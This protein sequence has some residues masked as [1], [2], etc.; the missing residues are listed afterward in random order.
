MKKCLILILICFSALS[1][2]SDNIVTYDEFIHLDFKSKS[3][4]IHLV[5]NFVSE[6]ERI[7]FKNQKQLRKSKKYQTY[8]KILNTFINSA[9]ANDGGDPNHIDGESCIYA[10]WNSKLHKSYCNHPYLVEANKAGS[11]TSELTT[12]K[13]II[14]KSDYKGGVTIN[15]EPKPEEATGC[16][17][18]KYEE[19]DANKNKIACNPKL[20]GQLDDKMFCVEAGNHS[21]NASYL[22]SQAIKQYE[23]NDKEKYNKIMKSIIHNFEEDGNNDERNAFT[24]MM[25]NMYNTCACGGAAATDQG[26]Y[27]T[28]NMNKAYVQNMFYSRTCYGVLSQT[29]RIKE[30]INNT[31]IGG[32]CFLDQSASSNGDK[33]WRD[34]L[35]SAHQVIDKELDSDNSRF[36]KSGLDKLTDWNFRLKKKEEIVEE[37]KDYCPMTPPKR[38]EKKAKLDP[39]V[40]TL[41]IEAKGIKEIDDTLYRLITP[42]LSGPDEIELELDKLNFNNKKTFEN[43]VYVPVDQEVF[44][45]KAEYIHLDQTLPSKEIE[46]VPPKFICTMNLEKNEKKASLNIDVTSDEIEVA[47]D[48]KKTIIIDIPGFEK[49]K[50]NNLSFSSDKFKDKDIEATA[51]IK[52]GE[53]SFD[54][55]CS[56]KAEK[57]EEPKVELASC[58]VELNKSI[59][60]KSGLFDIIPVI[61]ITSTEGSE[62]EEITTDIAKEKGIILTW[63]DSLNVTRKAAS[64]NTGTKYLDEDKPKKEKS[65][66]LPK[67]I[68]K[69]HRS[70]GTGPSITSVMQQNVDRVVSVHMKGEGCEDTATIKIPRLK[71]PAGND[72]PV[73]I[74]LDTS[75][76]GQNESGFVIQGTR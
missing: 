12:K 20:F 32:A 33:T 55:N 14:I 45:L 18:E 22:C 71:G 69:D 58:S 10:G 52:Y 66:K 56:Y 42:E 63:Y 73:Q 36:D 34:F 17:P 76:F 74:Q 1:F 53:K 75:G 41:A 40:N 50:D 38:I 3:K 47:E 39:E 48:K 35:N 19:Y 59:N 2:A 46:I 49:V 60:K 70:L 51:T 23:E 4:V 6:Y 9:Y 25:Y 61:K 64:T 62:E 8:K 15:E 28:G 67:G 24:S 11:Y 68:D 54:I 43:L 21:R 29:N 5:Q 7:Q 16:N 57:D 26:K 13:F 37:L 72:K 30:S 44:G 31:E 27:Y 65:K